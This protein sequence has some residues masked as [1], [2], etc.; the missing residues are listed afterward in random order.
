MGSEYYEIPIFVCGYLGASGYG[1]PHVL[2]HIIIIILF[3]FFI[4]ASQV[5]L[6]KENV[7]ALVVG[8]FLTAP[9]L[10]FYRS[11]INTYVAR[12]IGLT[13]LFIVAFN[14]PGVGGKKASIKP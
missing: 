2:N 13:I 11:A 5:G 8:P 12:L 7:L 1:F 6:T 9:L 10:L 4:S 14:S 3:L